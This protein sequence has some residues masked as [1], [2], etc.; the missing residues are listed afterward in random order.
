M[1]KRRKKDQAAEELDKNTERFTIKCSLNTVCQN[2]QIR[3]QIEWDVVN[4]SRLSIEASL[5]IHFILYRQFAK[6]VFPTRAYKFEDFFGHLVQQKTDKTISRLVIDPEYQ[7]L[8]A[9]YGLPLK[10]GPFEG[11][12]VKYAAETY[13]TCFKN[14]IVVHLQKRI[15][16][17]LRCIQQVVLNEDFTTREQRRDLAISRER[18]IRYALAIQP[19]AAYD[20]T[21]L[22]VLASIGLTEPIAN[23]QWNHFRFIEMLY[24]IQRFNEEVGAKNFKLVP[25]LK[26]RR[27]HVS[28][29]T[30]GLYNLLRLAKVKRD[31]K[32]SDFSRMRHRRWRNIFNISNYE[33][34]DRRF[35]YFIRTDGVAVSLTMRRPKS[36]QPADTVKKYPALRRKKNAARPMRTAKRRKKNQPPEPPGPPEPMQPPAEI[37]AMIARFHAGEFRVGVGLDLGFRLFY[38]GVSFTNDESPELLKYKSGCVAYNNGENRR[39]HTRKK[40]A[41]DIDFFYNYFAQEESSMSDCIYGY[42]RFRLEFF[43][44]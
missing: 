10:Y 9:S 22:L 7:K 34:R 13:E 31:G 38:G 8:R 17:F 35:D 27:H 12:I 25:I 6:G 28:Y 44:R 39:E 33:S 20:E 19:D 30:R 2:A 26:H 1:P 24:K 16:N 36:P 11:N 4:I 23:E 18:T 40:I 37:E 42:T 5:Y 15:N 29:C 41:A 3:D 43:D 14:N 32:E 21:L